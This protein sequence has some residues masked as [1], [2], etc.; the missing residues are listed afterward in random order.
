MDNTFGNIIVFPVSDGNIHAA[1]RRSCFNVFIT[2]DSIFENIESFSL[3]LEL[4]SFVEQSG[5]RVQPNVTEISIEGE[6]VGPS[7]PV[8]VFVFITMGMQSIVGQAEL[9]IYSCAASLSHARTGC[10]AKWTSLYHA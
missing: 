1:L 7:V 8:Y 6:F 3:L 4:D 2:D 9:A 5:I 10:R